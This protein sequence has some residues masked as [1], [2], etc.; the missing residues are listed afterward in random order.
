MNLPRK[1]SREARSVLHLNRPREV[2]VLTRMMDLGPEHYLLD[3]GCGDGYLTTKFARSAREVV[4]IDPD[5]KMLAVARTL[6]ARSNIRFDN[7]IAEK[8][9]YPDA[10][11]DRVVAVSVVEH[12]RDPATGL[13]EM[14]RV[15]KPGGVL[16]ISV[17]SLLPENSPEAFRNWHAPRYHVTTYFRLDQIVEMIRASGL[18]PDRE[19][20]QGIHTSRGAGALR[21]FYMRHK[22]CCFPL[23]PLFLA[24]CR[25]SD[26]IGLGGRMPPQI[27]IIRAQKSQGSR[28]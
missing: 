8:L 19:S 22:A 20:L 5:S 18:S 14:A 16:A 24:A 23:F 7:G 11:F 12:F 26:L 21:R 2:A 6:H 17:D 1:L 10:T 13:K 28:A 15:L 3:V 25:F 4:G 27:L 9:P